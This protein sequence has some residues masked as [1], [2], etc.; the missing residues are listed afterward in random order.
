M[1]TPRYKTPAAFK[2][3]LEDRLKKR[4]AQ[5]G[6]MLNRVRQR[7]VMERFL[8]RV[9][10]VLG[11]VATLKGGLALAFRLGAASRTTLDIDIARRRRGA[12]DRGLSPRA[13]A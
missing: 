13:A 1:S 10:E 4:A 12:G 2:V 7:F 5:R 8:A 11:P 3:A 6:V 9:V